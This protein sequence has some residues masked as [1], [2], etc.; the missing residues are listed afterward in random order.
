MHKYKSKPILIKTKRIMEKLLFGTREQAQA[1]AESND[2]LTDTMPVAVNLSGFEGRDGAPDT[3]SGETNALV[4]R[5]EKD[6]IVAYLA[7]WE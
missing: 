5:A 7:Y 2:W 1:Y 3:F 6:K 4:A